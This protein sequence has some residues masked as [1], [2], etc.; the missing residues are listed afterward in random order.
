MKRS[1]SRTFLALFTYILLSVGQAGAQTGDIFAEFNTS[2]GSFTCR[3]E[4]VLAPI[5]VANFIGLATGERSWIDMTNGRVKAEPFYD[6]LTFHRVV[7]NFVIQSGSRNG[8]GTDGPG[9][10]FQDEFNSQLK[11]D[12]G[13]LS[14]ANSGTH[15]NGSQFFVTVTN[16][17]W[18]DNKHSVFGKVVG[19]M[20][21]VDAINLVPTDDDNKPLEPVI[22]QQVAIRRTGTTTNFNIHAQ[23]LPVP[24]NEPFAL[25]VAGTNLVFTFTDRPNVVNKFF[26]SSNLVNWAAQDI[27]FDNTAPTN[28]SVPRTNSADNAFYQLAQI[29]YTLTAPESFRGRELVL[30]FGPDGKVTIKFDN[31]AGGTYRYSQG[32]GD[33]RQL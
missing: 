19:G 25:S 2:M 5:T 26:N 29:Q 21:V 14:M 10:V 1:A 13:V 31:S 4:H 11:H 27:Q 16:T 28:R 6:G 20:D 18:L 32:P 30:D 17:S 9:Y 3:L 24:T 33:C 22:L 8:K 23:G 7:T 12:R 15:A